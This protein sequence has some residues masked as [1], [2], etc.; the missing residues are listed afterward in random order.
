MPVHPALADAF[1]IRSPSPARAFTVILYKLGPLV[2][3]LYTL[4]FFIKERLECFMKNKG[5]KYWNINI[6]IN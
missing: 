3:F 6:K 1:G 2:L 4:E 5:Y